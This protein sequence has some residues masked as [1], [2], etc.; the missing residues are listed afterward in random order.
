MGKELVNIIF[1]FFKVKSFVLDFPLELFLNFSDGIGARS[2]EN[3]KLRFGLKDVI[4]N[5]SDI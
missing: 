1:G 5:V 4:D 2:H 3:M